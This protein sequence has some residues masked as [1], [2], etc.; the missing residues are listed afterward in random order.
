MAHDRLLLVLVL[1]LGLVLL[2]GDRGQ[3][4]G[5]KWSGRV[6]RLHPQI[7]YTKDR[8]VWRFSPT[9]APDLLYR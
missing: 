8:R 9:P 7:V 4:Y 1:A 5:K 2:M 3:L 6:R